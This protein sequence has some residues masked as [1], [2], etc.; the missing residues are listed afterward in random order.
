MADRRAL[1]VQ[2]LAGRQRPDQAVQVPGLEVV[3]L[4]REP[5]QV[6]HAVVGDHRGEHARRPAGYR[7]QRGPAAGRAA[8]DAQ[9]L[10]VR[11]AGLGQRGRGGGAVGDVHHAPLA[12][13]P[14]PVSAAVAGGAAVVH[15]DYPDAAA[16]EVR[17]LQVELGMHP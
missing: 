6:G 8:T 11:F 4:G 5:A 3:G 2:L 9:P 10:G 17:L 7:R 1:H 15:V 13:Q 12:A 16:G 14:F